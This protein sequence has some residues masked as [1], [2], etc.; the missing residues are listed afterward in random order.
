MDGNAGLPK[1][2][3]PAGFA[4]CL[5]GSCGR[6]RCCGPHGDTCEEAFAPQAPG[7]RL[8]QETSP[9]D[10]HVPLSILGQNDAAVETPHPASAWS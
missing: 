1:S 3:V 8:G 7:V 2:L 10:Q 6:H 4:E 5:K 9:K